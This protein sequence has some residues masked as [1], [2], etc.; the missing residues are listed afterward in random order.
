MFPTILE[1]LI[2]VG[3]LPVRLFGGSGW[4]GAVAAPVGFVGQLIP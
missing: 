4:R 1:G 3:T 2:V